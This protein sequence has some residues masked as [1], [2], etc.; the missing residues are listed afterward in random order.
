[1]EV[2]VQQTLK[3]VLSACNLKKSRLRRDIISC[4]EHITTFMHNHL[5]HIHALTCFISFTLHSKN[6]THVHRVLL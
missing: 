1:M 5:F 6:L 2:Q 4:K 3:N